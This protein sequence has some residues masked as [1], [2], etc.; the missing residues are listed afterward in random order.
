MVSHDGH[1]CS[2]RLLE[3]TNHKTNRDHKSSPART[4]TTTTKIQYDHAQDP[5]HEPC[6]KAATLEKNV[7]SVCSRCRPTTKVQ[8]NSIYNSNM[9]TNILDATNYVLTNILDA[10][11]FEMTLTLR[12]RGHGSPA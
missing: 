1:E 7:P 12:S 8:V 9:L 4:T 2:G 6:T 3:G 11:S 10:M 5:G